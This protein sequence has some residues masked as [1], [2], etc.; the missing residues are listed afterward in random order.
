MKK[1]IK[2]SNRENVICSILV[3]GDELIERGCVNVRDMNTRT[4]KKVKV[5]DVAEYV[6]NFFLK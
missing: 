4:Q 1:K 2:F 3:G 6:Y 5:E